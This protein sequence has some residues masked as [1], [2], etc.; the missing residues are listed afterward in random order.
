[1]S[2]ADRTEYITVEIYDQLYHL[3]GNDAAHLRALAGRVD[4]I[5]RAVA[6]QG[7]TVDSLRVAVLTALNLADELSRVEARGGVNLLDGK[8][9]AANLS[10]LLD[11]ILIEERKAD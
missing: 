3:A 9:R 8:A 4:A 10:A 5:M 6:S 2:P 7:R 1:M 11:Q